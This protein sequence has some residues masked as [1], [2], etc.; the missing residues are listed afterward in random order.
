MY[1]VF[2]W[3]PKIVRLMLNPK[4]FDVTKM[5]LNSDSFTDRQQDG[6]AM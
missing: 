2:K 5:K 3:N 1:Y 6:Q 4:N